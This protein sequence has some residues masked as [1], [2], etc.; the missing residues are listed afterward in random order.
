MDRLRKNAF[1]DPDTEQAARLFLSRVTEHYDVAGAL[2][3]GS[4]ARHDERA[5]SDLDI[6]VLIRSA[7]HRRIDVALDMADWAFDVLLETG[8]LVEALPLWEEEWEYP[9]RFNHPALIENIR[10]EGVRL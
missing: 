4:R 1:I 8:I 9:E 6:A 5:D 3:F 2:L 7:S 10:Q